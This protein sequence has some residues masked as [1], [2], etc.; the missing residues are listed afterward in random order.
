MNRT[1]HMNQ[2]KNPLRFGFFLMIL[3][4]LPSLLFSQMSYTDQH[5]VALSMPEVALLDIEPSGSNAVQ[6]EFPSSGINPGSPVQQSVVNNDSWINITSIVPMNK[7]RRVTVE[8]MGSLPTG[9]SLKVEASPYSG[10][11]EGNHGN[12]LQEVLLNNSPQ[13]LIANIGSSYTGNGVGNGYKLAYTWNWISGQFSQLNS[14][15]GSVTIIY[16]LV[17][18]D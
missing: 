16:T 3:V 9:T 14:Q 10:N 15:T 18:T 11:G 2:I 17:Q 8:M 5:S 1:L 13:N 7:S 4:F 6:M 12:P